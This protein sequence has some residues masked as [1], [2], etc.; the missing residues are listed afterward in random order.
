MI[1]TLANDE[2]IFS[3]QHTQIK[4]FSTCLQVAS[5]NALEFAFVCEKTK[6]YYLVYKSLSQPEPRIRTQEFDLKSIGSKLR[7]LNRDNID[8]EA[9]THIELRRRKLFISCYSKNAD[10]SDVADMHLIVLKTFVDEQIKASHKDGK[11]ALQFWAGKSYADFARFEPSTP[12]SQTGVVLRGKIGMEIMPVTDK[13]DMVF[14]FQTK[15]PNILNSNQAEYKFN[16]VLITNFDHEVKSQSEGVGIL[17]NSHLLKIRGRKSAKD[18]SIIRLMPAG[19]KHFYYQEEKTGAL[20]PCHFSDRTPTTRT[21]GDSH[22]CDDT[23]SL[24]LNLSRLDIWA[25]HYNNITT[26]LNLFMV[27]DDTNK[28]P[29]TPIAEEKN[30]ENKDETTPKTEDKSSVFSQISK[31]KDTDNIIAIKCQMGE[32]IMTVSNLE[33]SDQTITVTVPDYLKKAGYSLRYKIKQDLDEFMATYHDINDNVYSSLE[34]YLWVNFDNRVSRFTDLGE[35]KA[36]FMNPL[37]ITDYILQRGTFMYLVHRR[38]EYFNISPPKFQ[39]S[40]TIS[41]SV[42]DTYDISTFE[43]DKINEAQISRVD[44][45]F[46]TMEL[47]PI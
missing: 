6:V 41:L 21:T 35:Y 11:I 25:I 39:G 12:E 19:V 26:A 27:Y 38:D 20:V 36:S 15:N 4:D 9:C 17:S 24:D 43:N 37:N 13:F 1:E 42:Y 40:D 44:D 5:D 47:L 28:N 23:S 32:P 34:G 16:S 45:H 31:I 30:P 8:L 14:V 18:A 3:F 46:T 10:N 22:E 29:K 7:D 33:C 2:P